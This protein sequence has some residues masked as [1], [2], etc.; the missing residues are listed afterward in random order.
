MCIPT[1]AIATKYSMIGDSG[2]F[3]SVQA[4]ASLTWIKNLK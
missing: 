2:V 1:V 4:L 3:S